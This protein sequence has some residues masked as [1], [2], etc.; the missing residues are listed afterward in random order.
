MVV[1]VV[2][3]G[4]RPSSPWWPS[5]NISCYGQESKAVK[6]VPT[7]SCDKQKYGDLAN[8]AGSSQLVQGRALIMQDAQLANLSQLKK[9]TLMLVVMSPCP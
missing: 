8:Q 9:A 3:V 5:P 2:E 4:L 7:K 6:G 1:V